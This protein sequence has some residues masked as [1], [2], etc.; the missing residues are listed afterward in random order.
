MIPLS[1]R[2]IAA[3]VGGT[4]EGDSAVTVSAPPVLDGRQAEPGAL[5]VAFSGE[6]VDGHDYA[7]QAG[8]AARWPYSAPGPR[9]CP[10]SSSRTP[11]PRYRRSPPTWWPG[12]ATA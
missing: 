1:L 10:P 5:F 12:C 8:R 11:G 3:V 6:R 7:A 9:R 2:E 4:V